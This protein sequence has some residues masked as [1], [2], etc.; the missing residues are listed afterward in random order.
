MKVLTYNNLVDLNIP[1]KESKFACSSYYVNYNNLII[2]KHPQPRPFEIKGNIYK[3]YFQVIKYCQMLNIPLAPYPQCPEA[4]RIMNYEIYVNRYREL[5]HSIDDT[6]K[7]TIHTYKLNKKKAMKRII[8][9]CRLKQS[10]RFLAFYSISFPAGAK[11]DVLF[12]I[13]NKF[14]TSC[15]SHH[16]LE[17]YVWVSERQK[18]GTLHFHLLTNNRMNIHEVNQAMARSINNSVNQGK[19]TWGQSSLRLYNGVDVDSIQQPKHRQGENREAYRRRVKEMNKHTIKER[20][21]F[22]QQYMTKYVTKENSTFSHL[23]FHSSRDISQLFTSIVLTDHDFEQYSEELSDD[24]NDYV[25]YSSKD[26]TVYIFKKIQSD[27]IYSALDAQN[28]FLYEIYHQNKSSPKK[29]VTC[30]RKK[31]QQQEIFS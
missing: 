27:R 17:T 16:G 31:Q 21:K 13:W 12:E 28:Q 23:P 19:L 24:E 1:A 20:V 5:R 4:K 7:K 2:P 8:A 30:R 9:L 11:D 18:N 3:E 25:I 26:K 29:E 14:L 6:S 15:R 10:E 22:A